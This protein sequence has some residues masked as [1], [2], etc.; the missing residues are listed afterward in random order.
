MSGALILAIYK[1][2]CVLLVKIFFGCS[3][4]GFELFTGIF[5]RLEFSG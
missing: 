1:S 5:I 3:Y 4:L 2:Y